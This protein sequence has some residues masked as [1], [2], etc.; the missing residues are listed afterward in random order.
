MEPLQ[1]GKTLTSLGR[2]ECLALLRK[3][4]IGRLAVLFLGE[5]H[6]LPLNYAADES[7]VVVFRTAELTVATQAALAKVAFEVDAI[8]SERRE[9]WSVVVHGRGRDI[10][11][12]TD[13]D[14]VR[15]RHLP[16][17]P[18]APGQRDRWISIEPTQV[19][20]RRLAAVSGSVL[21]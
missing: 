9:G 8:D 10:T 12:A 13:P 4:R 21:I 3:G 14:A 2:E 1:E 18:W 11:D 15:L 5:P 17:V 6:V 19:T 16:V 20:G 7:G